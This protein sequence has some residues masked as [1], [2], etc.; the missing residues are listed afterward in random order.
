MYEFRKLFT[1]ICNMS[2]TAIFVILFV[3]LIRQ[4]LKKSYKSFSYYLWGLVG[5]RL[6]CPISFS[7][8]F[9]I[10][11]LP[12][13]KALTVSGST[14]EWKGAPDYKNSEMFVWEGRNITGGETVVKNEIVGGVE[15][16]VIYEPEPLLTVDKLEVF[17]FIWIFVVGILLTYQFYTYLKLKKRL[18]MAVLVKENIYEC[19]RISEPFVLG[20]FQPKIYIPFRLSDAEKTYILQ[21]EKYHIKRHDHQIKLIAILLLA[22]HWFNPFV[23]VAYYLMCKDMEMSCDEQ[24]LMK[25]GNEIKKEYSN[26]LLSFAMGKRTWALGTLAFGETS[27]A[28]RVKN[29][30]KFK[31]PGKWVVMLS[32]VLCLIV[33]VSGTANG[34]TKN[35]IRNI[36]DESGASA[37]YEYQFSDE[38]K[39]FAIYMEYY[40]YGELEEYEMILAG[41]FGEN[42]YERESFIGI[43]Q[44]ITQNE[45]GQWSLTF[46]CGI[47]G[48]STITSLKAGEYG[49]TGV[50]SNFYLENAGN[51]KEIE[52][53]QDIV[54]A[55]FHLDAGEGVK[56]YSC[57]YF[58]DED[59]KYYFL[60]DNAGVILVRMVFSEKDVYEIKEEYRTPTNIKDLYN[61]KNLYIGNHVADGQILRILEVPIWGEWQTELQTSEEPYGIIIH[62]ESY[63]ENAEWFDK[64]MLRDAAMFLTVTENAG[65]FEWTYPSGDELEVE[66][67]RYYVEDIEQMLGIENLK[68]FAE[69]EDSLQE[70]AVL[71]ES[72]E[73]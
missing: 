46:G 64:E 63:P 10:F 44:G 3:I 20:L 35:A 48:V 62:F 57:D 42:K 50:A 66:E 61:A 15:T 12:I 21:H 22:I 11:N 19:D 25:L 45:N 47:D 54:L 37:E 60:S 67:R 24:V 43:N 40:R 58:Q 7:S 59:T 6:L 51:W 38:I 55:A 17:A 1:T 34:E 18:E 28:D 36:T 41:E 13:L 5:F 69:S 56:S 31:R 65:F 32:T 23:W 27:I 52:K 70:L 49:Y 4:F 14:I 9:S 2:I 68:S 72:S 8:V 73:W 53:N 71:V 26:S 16:E 30:L 33:I 39:S 29:I